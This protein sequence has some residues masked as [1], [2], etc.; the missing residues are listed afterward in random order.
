MGEIVIG[1]MIDDN[2][3]CIAFD[4]IDMNDDLAKILKEESDKKL[5]SMDI[6]RYGYERLE[7]INMTYRDS[8]VSFDLANDGTGI[9][10]TTIT[11]VFVDDTDRLETC[12]PIPLKFSDDELIEVENMLVSNIVLVFF[13]EVWKR[14]RKDHFINE[15]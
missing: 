14:C 12:E 10:R 11:P 7:D 1:K 5:A 15:N 4:V 6:R 13:G 3:F 2:D 8:W 9:R